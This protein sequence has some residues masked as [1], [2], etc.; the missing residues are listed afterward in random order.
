MTKITF[1]NGST[2][3]YFPI[4]GIV[5]P[6]PNLDLSLPFIIEQAFAKIRRAIAKRKLKRKFGTTSMLRK[7]LKAI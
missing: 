1:K 6:K 3:T 5:S 2:I 4:D 7:N